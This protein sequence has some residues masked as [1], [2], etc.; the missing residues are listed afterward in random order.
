MCARHFLVS[1]VLVFLVISQVSATVVTFDDLS[2][3]ASGSFLAGSYQGLNWTA[4]RPQNGVLNPS[5]YPFVT[6]GAYYGVVSLSNVAAVF[7]GGEIDSTSTNFNFLSTYLTG[8]WNSNLNIQVQGFRAG[9]LIYEETVVAAATQSTLFAFNYLNIDRITFNPSGGQ[10]AFGTLP[11]SIFVM[12]N[13]TFEFV[14]E[15]STLVLA[16]LGALTLRPFLKRKRA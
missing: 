3:T 10:P 2:E 6:N 7:A 5:L 16:A 8:Y 4:V 9:N 14:P 12:D 13:F 11:D 1:T 15:P